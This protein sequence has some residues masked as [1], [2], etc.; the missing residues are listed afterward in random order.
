MA[1]DQIALSFNKGITNV[2]S[3]ATC[4]DNALEDS[5][6]MVYDNGEHRVIQKPARHHDQMPEGHTLLYVH[7]YG[8]F[9]RYITTREGSLYS[10]YNGTEHQIGSATGKVSAESIG[11]TLVI[12]DENN[13]T[14]LLWDTKNGSPQYRGI[15]NNIPQIKMKF[16]LSSIELAAADFQDRHIEIGPFLNGITVRDG[17][18]SDDDTPRSV[19]GH[20]FKSYEDAKAGLIGL[21][22]K[23]IN[24]LKEKKRFAFPFWVRY[25][26]RLYDGSYTHIS[27][28]VL[29]LPYG[30]I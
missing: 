13:L 4:D 26:T 14:Y 1:N 23:R 18:M 25:A 29:M 30:K 27:N 21:V 22:S 9:T 12:S 24:E 8:G 15:G 16:S 3:D 2:P 17:S 10:I 5:I 19:A 7:E 6:G 28:P 11:N 20:A